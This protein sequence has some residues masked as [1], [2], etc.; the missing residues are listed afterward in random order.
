MQNVAQ[1][2]C[3]LGEKEI[4][5]PHFDILGVEPTAS[6]KTA[7]SG[8]QM[9]A[10]PAVTTQ[11]F[12]PVNRNE[13]KL[14]KDHAAVFVR[15]FNPSGYGEEIDRAPTDEIYE[16]A[17]LITVARSTVDTPATLYG[18]WWHNLMQRISWHEE[19]SWKQNFDEHQ[20]TS[21]APKR[22]ATEWILFL[23]CLKN[24]PDFSEI[25]TRTEVVAHSEMPFFWRMDERR[26]LE[27]IV[28]LGFFDPSEKKW[29]ILDWK[30]NRITPDK[31]DILRG[32]YRPQ[33]AAYWKAV[34]EMTGGSVDAGIYST[35]TGQLI[36]YDP[37]ELA[38]EWERLRDLS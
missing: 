23:Q 38:T 35:S 21:P 4:N 29:F 33:I 9:D 8:E 13:F 11:P 10:G 14:A 26:C 18:H 20:V 6:S 2:K 24:D 1:L 37:G 7:G 12:P 3:L 5:R 17:P 25:L 30:T 31:I 36:E 28:D 19:S 27:G 34:T 32:Q 15:K 16:Q 22:S